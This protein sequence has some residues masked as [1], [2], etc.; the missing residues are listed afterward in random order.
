VGVMEQWYDVPVDPEIRAA[1][2]DAALSLQRL[3][4]SSEEFKPH[5][6]E[7]VPNLWWFFF[8]QVSAPSLRKMISG[9]EDDAFPTLHEFLA[10][11]ARRPEPTGED[12]MYNLAA[13]DAMRCAFLRQM[14]NYPVLLSPA[15]GITAFP[16]GG[17]SFV[18]EGRKIGL[19]QAM[20]PAT[21]VNLF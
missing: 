13:R 7:R 11:A 14:E 16:H 1:V 15:S 8:G 21:F 9:R 10:D 5:G 12:I 20:M 17:R 18:V 2:R 4:I 3:R 19:F 6:M